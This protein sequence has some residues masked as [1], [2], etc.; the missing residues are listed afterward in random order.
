MKRA[1]V[2]GNDDYPLEHQKLESCVDDANDMHDALRIIGFDVLRKRNSP[3][4]DTQIATE[5]FLQ[6]IQ[7][8]DTAFFYFSGHGCQLDGINYLIPTNDTD[9]DEESIKYRALNAQ[10][11]TTSVHARRPGLF[12]MVLDCC[13]DNPFADQASLKNFFGF[14]ST[15]FKDGLAPMKGPPSTIIAYACAPDQLSLAGSG[16]QRNSA[17]TCTLLHYIVLPMDIKTVFQK[18]AIDVHKTTGGYQ[19]PYLSIN[20]NKPMYL[21]NNYM[22]NN[23]ALQNFLRGRRSC[24]DNLRLRSLQSFNGIHK[25]KHLYARNCVIDRFPYNVP[26]LEYL[27]LSNNSIL[28]YNTNANRTFDFNSNRITSIPP[29]IRFVRNL[30]HLSLFD[31]QLTFL[32]MEMFSIDTLVSLNI[33]NNSFNPKE[34]NRIIQTFKNKTHPDLMLHY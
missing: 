11:L 32:P 33:A 29:E 15:R 9:I 21:V 7:P 22:V 14:R 25:L 20:Y 28:G 13:R 16:N 23:P 18:T 4:K 2:I 19:K 8:G 1:L 17:Y 34:L 24:D 6:S 31:N 26:D 3:L 5:K 27:L 10:K 30:N 12:I